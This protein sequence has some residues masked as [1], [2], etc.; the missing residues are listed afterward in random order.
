MPPPQAFELNLLGV[1]K[2]FTLHLEDTQAVKAFQPTPLF[3]TCVVTRE[4]LQLCEP[5]ERTPVAVRAW[6]DV[7]A[8]RSIASLKSTKERAIESL[9]LLLCNTAATQ[10]AFRG[11]NTS[12]EAPP[13]I[14]VQ[15]RTRLSQELNL[16]FE[17]IYGQGSQLTERVRF[18]WGAALQKW[19]LKVHEEHTRTLAPLRFQAFCEK[20]SDP[21]CERHLF[22][23][24]RLQDQCN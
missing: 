10:S 2:S 13:A 6:R 3:S 21:Q 18:A 5:Q 15:W 12:P 7:D 17:V 20:C 11:A 19:G 23:L 8:D 1:E 22:G 9:N 24:G 14:G 4:D 16:P